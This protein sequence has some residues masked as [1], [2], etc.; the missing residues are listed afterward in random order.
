[1]KAVISVSDKTGLEEFA[2]NLLDFGLEIVATEGTAKFLEQRGIEVTRLSKYT[3]MRESRV[4]KTL[5]PLLYRWI[6]E[7]EVKVVA[8]IPYDFKGLDSIDIGGISLI[9]AAAKNYDKVLV[10]F[11]ADQYPLVVEGLKTGSLDI[12]KKLAVEAFKFTSEYDRRISEWLEHEA[13]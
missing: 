5:H 10:A 12:R 6:Y 13:P 4:L 3:G 8:V 9:R 7:G 11:K 2:G 1:M